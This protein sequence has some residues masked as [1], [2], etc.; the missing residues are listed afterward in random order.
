MNQKMAGTGPFAIQKYVS[1]AMVDL[2][3]LTRVF[4]NTASPTSSPK[5]Q[6]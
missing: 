2:V 1:D 6:P 3:A 5:Y 4:Q